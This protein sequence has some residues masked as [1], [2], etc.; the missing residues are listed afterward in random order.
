[1][2]KILNFIK[3][4]KRIVILIGILLITAIVVIISIPKVKNNMIAMKDNG[5]YAHTE[6]GIIKEEE[7]KGIKF[8]NISMLTKKDYTTFTADITNITDKDIKEER[9]HISL[10]DDN[11]KEVVKLLAYFPGGL[12]KDET[13]TIEAIAH[14][15]F[16]DATNKEI[17]D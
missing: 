13:K 14:G 1:M 8:S 3:R 17:I 5:I 6:E 10:K 16:T 15:N 11:K 4:K 12:K 9:L 7:Y 2:K